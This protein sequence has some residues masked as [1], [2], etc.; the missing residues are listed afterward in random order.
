MNQA[1]VQALRRWGKRGTIKVVDHIM[2]VLL[3]DGV[4]A[5]IKSVDF[6]I[7]LVRHPDGIQQIH[8]YLFN[9]CHRQRNYAALWC[10]RRQQTG[11]LV[12]ACQRGLMDENQAFAV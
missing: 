6:A 3:S 9:G 4:I 2:Q 8:Y 12:W 1:L 11:F 10:K 5:T 7:D